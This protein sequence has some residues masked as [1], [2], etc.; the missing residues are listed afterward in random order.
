[1]RG[2]DGARLNTSMFDDQGN[3]TVH[4]A[5]ITIIPFSRTTKNE[6]GEAVPFDLSTVTLR[7][8]AYGPGTSLLMDFEPEIDGNDPMS[9]NIVV[10]PEQAQSLPA[11]PVPYSLYMLN[12]AGTPLPPILEATIS[13]KGIPLP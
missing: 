11:N 6:L 12:D 7:F 2:A 10:T 1:M 9:R 3:I 13:A 4:R 5:A 8:V